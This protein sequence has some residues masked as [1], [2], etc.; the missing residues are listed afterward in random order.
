MSEI[1]YGWVAGGPPAYVPAAIGASEV[2]KNLSGRWMGSDAAGYLDVADTDAAELQGW[3]EYGELTAPATDGLL[4]IVVDISPNSVYRMPADDTPALT[5][6]WETC[7]IV[8]ASNIQQ[9][10]VGQSNQDV[11]IICGFNATDLTVDARMNPS[12]MGS[13]GVA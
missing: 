9:A 6:M 12:K 10:D 11:L 4:E 7:D 1:R 8:V 5:D 2:F 13:V 3:G